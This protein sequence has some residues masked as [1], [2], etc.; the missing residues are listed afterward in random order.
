MVK[1]KKFHGFTLV[2]LVIVIAVIAVLAAVLVPTFSS[3]IDRANDSADLQ[4]V[5]NMNA[6]I[7]GIDERSGATSE[8]LRKY[9]SDNG[10]T[11]I[12]TKN[13]NN[14]IV[15]NTAAG[16]FEKLNLKGNNVQP[17]R[18]EELY[19]KKNPFSLEE[20]IDGYIIVSTKG[21]ALSEALYDL[22]NLTSKTDAEDINASINRIKDGEIKSSVIKLLKSSAFI[23]DTNKSVYLAFDGDKVSAVQE[24]VGGATRVVF[25]E[26]LTEF[27][28]SVLDGAADGLGVVIPN[29]ITSVTGEINNSQIIV[30]GNIEALDEELA[31][32]EK[33]D[34]VE[35]VTKAKDVVAESQGKAF[36]KDK[37]YVVNSAVAG[38]DSYYTDLQKAIT[39]A[40]VSHNLSGKERVVTIAEEN[41]TISIKQGTKITVP[42][43]IVLDIPLAN[44]GG[45]FHSGYAAGGKDG[46]NASTR[47]ATDSETKYTLEVN[48]DLVIEGKV[49]I[50]GVISHEYQYYQGHTSGFHGKIT[51]NGNITVKDGGVMDV[52]G[53]VKGS[54]TLNIENNGIV[55]QPF[56]VTDFSG[57]MN[58]GTLYASGQSPFLRYAMLNIQCTL[59]ANYGSLLI[60]HCN[61]YASGAYNRTEQV[62]IGYLSDEEAEKPAALADFK[63]SDTK[64]LINLGESAYATCIYS[65]DGL[66]TNFD[67]A[68]AVEKNAN[69]NL[70][71]DIGKTSVTI[72]G[73][74]STGSL[75]LLNIVS[76][77][78]VLFP[79]PYNF[80]FTFENGTFDVNNRYVLLPGAKVTVKQDAT[81]R[82]KKGAWFYVM[83]E[84]YQMSDMSSKIY[85]SSTL[86]KDNNISVSGE[87]WVE[88]KMIVENG[89]EKNITRVGGIVNSNT[90]GA[91]VIIGDQTGDDIDGQYID[92]NGS[93]SVGAVGNYAVNMSSYVY[94]FRLYDAAGSEDKWFK[95]A[96]GC[97]YTVTA[98]ENTEITVS[99]NDVKFLVKVN[100]GDPY[101]VCIHPTNVLGQSA[102]NAAYFKWKN[103]EADITVTANGKWA[104]DSAQSEKQVQSYQ[105]KIR[106][107][108][109]IEPNSIND[110]T[111]A[112]NLFNGAVGVI[113]EYD[114]LSASVR[115]AVKANVEAVGGK[116]SEL[117]KKSFP[118]VFESG[119][120]NDDKAKAAIQAE[121]LYKTL[122]SFI[123]GYLDGSVYG[124][125][126]GIITEHPLMYSVS[127]NGGEE[128]FSGNQS[129]GS[130][131]INGIN[132]MLEQNAGNEVK[133]MLYNDI[134]VTSYD[135][136]RDRKTIIFLPGSKTTTG[137]RCG[138]IVPAN[139]TLILDLNGN[140]IISNSSEAMYIVM[141]EVEKGATLNL[142]N[143]NKDEPSTFRKANTKIVNYIESVGSL[144]VDNVDFDGA[145][146][147]LSINGGNLSVENSEMFSSGASILF[148]YA[149]SGSTAEPIEVEKISNVKIGV[150]AGSYC[151]DFY[152]RNSIHVKEISNVETLDKSVGSMIRF[153]NSKNDKITIDE[154]SNCSLM[155]NGTSSVNFY[156]EYGN[157]SIGRIN[158]CYFYSPKSVISCGTNISSAENKTVTID[159]IENSTFDVGDANVAAINIS[160]GFTINSFGGVVSAPKGKA[161]R[162]AKGATLKV[163]K[164]Y[165]NV[166]SAADVFDA[167][168]YAFAEFVQDEQLGGTADNWYIEKIEAAGEEYNGMFTIVLGGKRLNLCDENGEKF[169]IWRGTNAKDGSLD[170]LAFTKNGR[171]VVGWYLSGDETQELIDVNTLDNDKSISAKYEAADKKVAQ[172][173]S[174]Q[175]SLIQDAI[176]AAKEG[177][178]ISLLDDWTEDGIVFDKG[179][180]LTLNLNGHTLSPYSADAQYILCVNS[181]TLNITNSADGNGIIRAALPQTS[182]QTS[183]QTILVTGGTLNL[184]NVRIMSEGEKINP[185]IRISSTSEATV[186][187]KTGAVIEQNSKTTSIYSTIYY[188][189]FMENFKATV[190]INMNDDSMILSNI[191]GIYLN[192]ASSTADVNIIMKDTAQILC[193]NAKRE[194]T[195]MDLSK[196]KTKDGKTTLEIGQ[197]NMIVAYGSSGVALVLGGLY[198]AKINGYLYVSTTAIKVNDSVSGVSKILLT[199]AKIGNSDTDK[200]DATGESFSQDRD[201]AI[202]KLLAGMIVDDI[203][204]T[205]PQHGKL[206][207]HD[208]IPLPFTGASS[209]IPAMKFINITADC[210]Y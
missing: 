73:N 191:G 66:I 96:P 116:L 30:S 8:N 205:A 126:R 170:A 9:L 103:A 136:E 192:S 40:E 108:T 164:G 100:A 182:S 7:A 125:I 144:T 11:E 43:G 20:I 149:Y 115:A 35:S 39:E 114:T 204:N 133:I 98:A 132:T 207:S 56:I 176:D 12:A 127:I 107:Y 78:E 94:P 210:T 150:N 83:D 60:A 69:N 203:D 184:E 183:Y 188:A 71:G 138:I 181:G 80:D 76:T 118:L 1:K 174:V 5:T 22:H 59:V 91:K 120:V 145:S 153:T 10:L 4:L 142:C 93:F 84:M 202:K 81:L 51:N 124:T 201:S 32:N 135:K 87:L 185:V 34:K 64:G 86:L 27:D 179:I 128:E 163:A 130:D 168:P 65:S 42:K 117:Y 99:K 68:T 77:N 37:Y 140:D 55:A 156:F 197:D 82:I 13:K 28:I 137:Y 25:N 18:A 143:S 158:E 159:K 44:E 63:I 45:V 157:V 178:T 169:A 29:N 47:L 102:G 57:G 111:Q 199:N 146:N 49:Q 189:I 162:L 172:I 75:S 194:V 21:N 92:V 190:N 198:D 141:F 109:S 53:Y 121:K 54:G 171:K 14:I 89:D 23:I 122:P 61:L 105:A 129:W 206:V 97:S 200:L 196:G 52:W 58:S 167:E 152:S 166:Q 186:N 62:V 148:K 41:G 154:I 74:A 79:V 2:E 17:V 165:F 175:Y 15:Y 48:G 134:T 104:Q 50:G 113:T 70:A 177:N 112:L 26:S 24:G 147:A 101:D 31:Q 161:F 6:V 193:Y 95:A 72:N 123:L 85:P 180:N 155:A 131:E 67:N 38:D 36:T 187:M 209:N 110:A 19:A 88:G 106:Q 139:V 119:E 16:K 46:F 208:A 195:G 3:M 151:I 160:D 90:A 173:G 33:I